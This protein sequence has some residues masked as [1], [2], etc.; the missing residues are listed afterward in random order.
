LQGGIINGIEEVLHVVGGN[1]TSLGEMTG[2][3]LV[4]ETL[5]LVAESPAST[6]FK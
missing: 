4:N 2:D 5:K 1:R 6:D 3:I